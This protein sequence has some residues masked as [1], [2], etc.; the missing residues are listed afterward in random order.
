MKPE[1]DAY[2]APFTWP[3]R[4]RPPADWSESF[5]G[6]MDYFAWCNFRDPIGHIVSMNI[7]FRE[8]IDELVRLR[9]KHG[10]SAPKGSVNL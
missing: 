2:R 6:I 9:S 4:Y 3:R 5:K 7:P 10:P 1:H 8:L